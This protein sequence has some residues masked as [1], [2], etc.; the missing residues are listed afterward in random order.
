MPTVRFAGAGAFVPSRSISNERI[1]KAFPG[2]TAEHILEKTGILERRYLWEID[3]Q[4]NAI[5]PPDDDLP[6]YPATSTDM[7]EIALR[8]ALTQAGVEGRELDALFVV[9]C[10]PDE[11]NFNH[12]AMLLHR[13]LG[14]RSDTFALVVDDGC[15]GTP[16]IIDM[17]SKM[18][19]SGRFKTVAV[20]ASSLLSPQLNR[21]VYTSEVVPAP[22]R[23]P[24]NAYLSAYVFGD[25]AGAVVLRADGEEGQGILR[26]MSGNAHSELVLR[27]GGGMMRLAHQGRA[28]PGD[29]AFVVDGL[30]VAESYSIYMRRCIEGALAEHPALRSEVKRYYFHQPNKRLMDHFVQKVGLPAERVAMNVHHYGNTS[31]AGMLILLAEDLEAGRVRLG[32]GDLVM[33][34]AVGANVHYGAQL[35][36]L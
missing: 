33:V 24:L 22:G 8:R 30:K 3:A 35:V 15:G 13:R 1:A 9:T 26:S 25:G 32:S 2:W 12:D 11:L 36:R 21:E 5:P 29:M 31:A 14:C 27:R 23:K 19:E 10:T 16:Y 34:A 28:R 17:A 6:V 18:M 20:V 7:C 4:G